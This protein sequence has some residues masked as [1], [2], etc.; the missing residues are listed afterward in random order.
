MSNST[1]PWSWKKA[2]VRLIA[3]WLT[4]FLSPLAGGG[5]A[6]TL[7]FEDP[8]TRI[9]VTALVSSIIITGLA[10]GKMLDEWTRRKN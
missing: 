7:P 6:F 9:V 10:G 4:A 1:K 2:N 3:N 5:I 8:T